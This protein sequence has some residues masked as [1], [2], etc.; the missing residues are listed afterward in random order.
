M[1]GTTGQKLTKK[2]IECKV[3]L[4]EDNWYPSFVGKKHYKCKVCYDER[5]IINRY[6]K[7]YG[8]LNKAI[9]RLIYISTKRRY[10][11]VKEGQVY[12]ICNP[13]FPSWCK[14]GMAVDAED[15]L[16]QYQTSSPH[17]DYELIKCYSAYD[18]REAEV[19]AH[20]ELEK[21][22]MR[23]GEW[24]MCTGY[25]AQKILDAMFETKGE[26]LGLL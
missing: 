23:K 11:A 6:K 20:T 24:F 26:Q 13:A 25:N 2:C 16:K 4:N 15:R 21:H 10:D 8:S 12:V 1:S 17:R 7:K 22:Y 18:R 3:I 9:A 14:V 19:L 5:R